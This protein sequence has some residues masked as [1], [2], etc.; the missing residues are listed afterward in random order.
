[1]QGIDYLVFR[2]VLFLFFLGI[3]SPVA[4]VL[5]WCVEYL[6]PHENL[7]FLRWASIPVL[8]AWLFLLEWFPSRTAQYM[9]FEDKPFGVAVKLVYYDLRLLL[10]FLPLI[11]HWFEFPSDKREFDDE[12]T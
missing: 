4:L 1:M 2:Y 12:D 11:G 7:R 5:I 6:D 10:A 8:L 3:T 9:A